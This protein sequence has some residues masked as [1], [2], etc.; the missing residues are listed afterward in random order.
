LA[1]FV[2]FPFF[3]SAR[4]PALKIVQPAF[5]ATRAETTEHELDYV[6]AVAVFFLLAFFLA[7]LA[8]LIVF[9]INRT[10]AKTTISFQALHFIIFP[11]SSSPDQ[12]DGIA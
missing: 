5:T 8:G 9:V 1:F 10:A 6:P 11:H 2:L 4:T 7:L 12:D 3:I